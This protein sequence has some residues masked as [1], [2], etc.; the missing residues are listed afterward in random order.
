MTEYGIRA[1]R[2]GVGEFLPPT[3]GWRF[4]LKVVRLLDEYGLRNDGF[5]HEALSVHSYCSSVRFVASCTK[6]P[7]AMRYYIRRSDPLFEATCEHC[8]KPLFLKQLFN[9][10]GIKSVPE[11]FRD[12]EPIPEGLDRKSVV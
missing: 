10:C 2:G 12:Y 9:A 1:A 3:N 5:W 11:K 7:L 6:I 4:G 8:S